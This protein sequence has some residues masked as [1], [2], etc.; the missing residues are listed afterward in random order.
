MEV[1]KTGKIPKAKMYSTY[2]LA[3]LC[4]L[5]A[6]SCKSTAPAKQTKEPEPVTEEVVVVETPDETIVMEEEPAIVIEEEM[7]EETVPFALLEET[8]KSADDS[9]KVIM[10]NQIDVPETDLKDADSALLSAKAVYDL[11]EDGASN[12]DVAAAYN[13]ASL[14]LNTYNEA[15]SGYWQVK[16]TDARARSI[17][18]QREALNMKA[19]VAVRDDFNLSTDIFNNGESNYLAGFYEESIGFFIESETMY[20]N[21]SAITSEKRRLAA[22]ALQAAEK[23][24]EES[25]RIAADADSV[26]ASEV[27][28]KSRE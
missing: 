22:A 1:T 25:E 6:V 23:K 14:A 20:I 16:A 4:V 21:L 2:A 5:F 12:D 8:I 24:I 17:R 28:D 9:R 7:T 15:I 10:D 3:A 19:D 27:R 11:G 26:L 13:N 18:A